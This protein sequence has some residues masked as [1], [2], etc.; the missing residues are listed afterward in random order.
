M[1]AAQR[2]IVIDKPAGDVFAFFADP[3]ND[4]RWR[5]T[6]RRSPRPGRWALGQPCTRSWRDLGVEG[7]RPTSR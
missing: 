2:K 3:S 7:S 1:P 4:P 6:S 5:R